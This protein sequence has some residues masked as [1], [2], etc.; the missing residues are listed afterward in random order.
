MQGLLNSFGVKPSHRG[1]NAA[2]L[3]IEVFISI[4]SNGY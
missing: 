1:K 3:P 2:G 4:I